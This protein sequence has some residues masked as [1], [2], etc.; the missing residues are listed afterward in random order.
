MLIKLGQKLDQKHL[1]LKSWKDNLFAPLIKILPAG[2]QPNHLTFFR[3]VIVLIW[4]PGAI[5]KPSICQLP[6]FLAVYF[7]DLLDGAL[8]R[9]KNQTTVFG[10]YFDALT[11]R[12]NHLTLYILVLQLVNFRL[13][14]L[15]FFIVWEI[16]VIILVLLDWL[17][18]NDKITYTRISLQFLAK[19]ILWAMLI[20]EILK[21]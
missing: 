15:N 16:F 5:L 9:L 20:C 10:K 14:I 12:L 2:I 4:L 11:D 18:K 17:I 8:A 13:I 19:I 6:I 21:F 3:L 1:R 7:F